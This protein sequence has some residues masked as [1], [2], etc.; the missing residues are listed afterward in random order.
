MP[1]SV[2]SLQSLSLVPRKSRFSFWNLEVLHDLAA[3]Y[4]SSSDPSLP[5]HSPFEY[6]NIQ[7][8]LFLFTIL[9][10]LCGIQHVTLLFIDWLSLWTLS[11]HHYRTMYILDNVHYFC[12]PSDFFPFSLLQ[13]HPGEAMKSQIQF[14][15]PYSLWECGKLL[16]LSECWFFIHLFFS[17][18]WRLN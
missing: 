6:P 4:F 14:F 13:R 15:A 9:S 17:V 2:Q 12:S 11:Q 8:E 7:I 18:L 3:T 10:C 5:L 16:D 1:S